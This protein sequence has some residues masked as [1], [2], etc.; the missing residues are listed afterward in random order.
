M[1]DWSYKKRQKNGDSITYSAIEITLYNRLVT[2]K[3]YKHIANNL[4]I[5]VFLQ[6]KY[7]VNIGK[8]RKNKRF[9]TF[10]WFDLLDEQIEIRIDLENN[11]DLEFHLLHE[12]IS[13]KERHSTNKIHSDPYY[14]SR[15]DP[16]FSLYARI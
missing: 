3:R 7:E 1:K 12:S 14:R 11:L 13:S 8:T 16:N 10:I 5:E 4:D 9:L 6:S 2:S 15:S